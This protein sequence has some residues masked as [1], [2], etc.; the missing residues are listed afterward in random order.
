MAFKHIIEM[1]LTVVCAGYLPSG[2]FALTSNSSVTRDELLK[3]H[4]LESI[5]LS[6]AVANLV[7][8]KC[9]F[10]IRFQLAPSI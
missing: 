5:F 7:R 10:V 1:V 3:L 8:L 2:R 4:Y 6:L 9:K